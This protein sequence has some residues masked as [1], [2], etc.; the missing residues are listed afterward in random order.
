MLQ[1]EIKKTE[2][3]TALTFSSAIF[4][5]ENF[6][7]ADFVMFQVS[8]AVFPIKFLLL[9]RISIKS[10]RVRVGKIPR[11]VVTLHTTLVPE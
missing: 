10:K 5:L 9:R 11:P 6:I 7:K 2:M 3:F 4:I 8:T 1:I